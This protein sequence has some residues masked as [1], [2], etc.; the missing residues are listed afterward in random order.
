MFARV[1]TVQGSPDRLEEAVRQY[2]DELV[3]AARQQ[4]GFKGAYLLVDR[5]TGKGMSIT[6]WAT[7][8]DLRAS[9]TWAD[10]QRAQAAQTAGGSGALTREVYEVGVQA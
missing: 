6:L 2:R 8:D 3:P 7:E 5:G 10:Q 9:D 4:R 1:S